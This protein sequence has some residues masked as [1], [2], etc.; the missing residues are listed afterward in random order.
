MVASQ[1]G[2]RSKGL[3]ITNL[4][5]IKQEVDLYTMATGTVK[6]SLTGITFLSHLMKLAT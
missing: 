2:P 1:E 5:I 4:L 6:T 3:D